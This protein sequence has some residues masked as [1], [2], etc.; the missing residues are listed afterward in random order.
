MRRMC[1]TKFRYNGPLLA[2]LVVAV[3]LPLM[4]A[5]APDGLSQSPP[6]PEAATAD[7]NAP[8]GTNTESLAALELE[9]TNAWQR[10]LVIVN[11]PV[12]AYTRKPGLHPGEYG[13]GGWFHPGAVTPDFDHVD[14]RQSQDTSFEK[15][16]YITSDVTPNLVFLG[17]DC[18][19]NLMTKLFYTNR[20]LPKHRL[21][22]AEMVEINRLYRIIGRCL[23]EIDRR[24]TPAYVE[25]AVTNTESEAGEIIPGQSF[26]AIRKIP[27]ETRLLYAGIGIGALLLLVI[28]LRLVRGR[29]GAD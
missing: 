8:A 2:R 10:V 7:T 20:N 26:E 18:E 17:K 19:F 15:H 16:T 25:K 29:K 13:P 6:K 9:L 14:V 1:S 28:V 12:T 21:S 5:A 23:G 11:K 4:L 3:F 22:E 27:R 24:Q